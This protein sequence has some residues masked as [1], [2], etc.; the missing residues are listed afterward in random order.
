MLNLTKSQA[1]KIAKELSKP[2]VSE[3]LAR[4]VAK[5]IISLRKERRMT[6]EMRERRYGQVPLRG[7]QKDALESISRGRRGVIKVEME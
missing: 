7:Y 3:A 5:A 6:K 1:R 4:M 2:E